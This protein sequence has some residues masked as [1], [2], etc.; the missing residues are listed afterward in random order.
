MCAHQYL[1]K[2]NLDNF[3]YFRA[4]DQTCF[5]WHNRK[6]LIFRIE[7]ADKHEIVGKVVNGFEKPKVRISIWAVNGS[8][9]QV[10]VVREVYVDHQGFAAGYNIKICVMVLAL[11]ITK[12]CFT[13]KATPPLA[14]VERSFL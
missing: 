5:S 14:P 8:L 12:P 2:L 10:L 3:E 1:N 6:L 4:L 9:S 7:I 13:I 11:L